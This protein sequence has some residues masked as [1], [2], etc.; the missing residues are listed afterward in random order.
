MSFLFRHLR[1]YPRSALSAR[2]FRRRAG[3][4]R[5]R[6]SEIVEPSALIEPRRRL[7]NVDG[8]DFSEPGLLIRISGSAANEFRWINARFDERDEFLFR[9]LLRVSALAS[10][11]NLPKFLESTV[12]GRSRRRRR[13][14]KRAKRAIV[15]FL[16]ICICIC[17]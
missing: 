4:G 1:P 16:C 7:S 2:Q 10:R 9:R 3:V 15:I 13:P 5:F 12:S 6:G 17:I 14:T 11:I 8:A